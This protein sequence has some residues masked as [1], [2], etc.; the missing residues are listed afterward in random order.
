MILITDLMHLII[1]TYMI[2]RNKLP[3]RKD[4]FFFPLMGIGYLSKM[5]H[6]FVK[7]KKKYTKCVANKK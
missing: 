3:I 6:S 2:N 1:I 7:K 5:K 4:I